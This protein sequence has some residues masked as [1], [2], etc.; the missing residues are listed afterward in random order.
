M[1]YCD[2]PKLPRGMM[3]EGGVNISYALPRTGKD[4]TVTYWKGHKKTQK[5]MKWN[6]KNFK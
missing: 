2:D 6:G 5:T 1:T 4:L 3:E